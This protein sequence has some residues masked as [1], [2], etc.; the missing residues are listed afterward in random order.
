MALQSGDIF[1]VKK[2]GTQ[3]SI[4]GY[5]WTK[6]REGQ[7]ARETRLGRKLELNSQNLTK[8]FLFLFV[9]VLGRTN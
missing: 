6:K 9:N 4:G 5:C 7:M 2:R 8:H 3:D 1:I